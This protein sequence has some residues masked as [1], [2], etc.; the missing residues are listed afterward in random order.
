M[1][2]YIWLRGRDRKLCEV[3]AAWNGAV[4]VEGIERV[5][6]NNVSALS[7]PKEK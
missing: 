3:S 2:Y 6:N 5:Q 4:K 1:V 7:R